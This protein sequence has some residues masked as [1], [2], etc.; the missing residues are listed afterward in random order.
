M[1]LFLI[2]I[3]L[4]SF[5][6]ATWRDIVI[7]AEE[8][9]AELYP[10]EIKLFKKLEPKKSPVKQLT[11]T[12]SSRFSFTRSVSKEI[13]ERQASVQ[14][15]RDGATPICVLETDDILDSLHAVSLNSGKPLNRDR[16]GGNVSN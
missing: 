15:L 16:T 10:E 2:I 4:F 7:Y 3:L 1:Y 8:L 11:R 12:M 14:Q 6:E 13:Y 5:I 9:L